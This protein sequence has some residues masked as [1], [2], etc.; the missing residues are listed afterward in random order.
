MKSLPCIQC[1]ATKQMRES[2]Y[3]TKTI[4]EYDG[5]FIPECFVKLAKLDQ[6]DRNYLSCQTYSL[7]LYQVCK[8]CP[9]TCPKNTI[10]KS[11]LE[12]LIALVAPLFGADK[13]KQQ[14]VKDA[15]AKINDPEFADVKKSLE[16]VSTTIKNIM[17]GKPGASDIGKKQLE[18][19]ATKLKDKFEQMIK[20]GKI[21]HTEANKIRSEIKNHDSIRMAKEML[22]GLK[23]K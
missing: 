20:D 9:L 1:V 15:T 4:V 14:A 18:A 22:D 8:T 13:D 19:E 12:D 11:P 10:Q 3:C 2:E 23:G 6:P 5:Q 17:E 16:T 21:S 7:G